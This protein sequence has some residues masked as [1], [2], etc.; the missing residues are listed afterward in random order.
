MAGLVAGTAAAAQAVG[1]PQRNANAP[2]RLLAV[3]Q[4]DVPGILM[5]VARTE[6]SNS[7]LQDLPASP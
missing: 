7:R 2:S 4:R 6:G 1:T 3:F 5:A